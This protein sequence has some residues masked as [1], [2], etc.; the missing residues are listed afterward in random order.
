MA[1]LSIIRSLCK[2]KGVS[3]KELANKI[4]MTENGLQ[5]ILKTNSTKIETLEKIADVLKVE[6]IDFF[7]PQMVETDIV[8]TEFVNDVHNEVMCKRF[9]SFLDK[10]NYYKDD[11][12]FTIFPPSGHY[13]EMMYFNIEKRLRFPFNHP[14]KPKYVFKNSDGASFPKIPNNIRRI[15]FSKWPTEFNWFISEN[16]L[17]L[18]A[19]YFPVFH[20]NLLNIVDYLNDGMINNKEVL[21]Y[22][23]EWRRIEKEA[24]FVVIPPFSDITSR[25]L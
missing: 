5:R 11:F 22:W 2:S 9:N 17:L 13:Y 20:S 25:L 4:S 24:E 1:N 23:E 10:L 8:F 15:P 16:I 18:E 6:I 14:S 3:L 19:F 12:I 21:K 7:E